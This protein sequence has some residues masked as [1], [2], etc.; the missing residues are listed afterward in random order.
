ME[1]GKT[2]MGSKTEREEFQKGRDQKP[3]R[4]RRRKGR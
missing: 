2:T 3:Y 4:E 1:K